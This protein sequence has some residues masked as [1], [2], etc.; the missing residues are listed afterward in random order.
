[1]GKKWLGLCFC[2]FLLGAYAQPAVSTEKVD[3]KNK[4]TVLEGTTVSI[5]YTVTLEDK[6][7][8]D[9]NVGGKPL[10]YVQGSGHVIPGV[11]KAMLG[12]KVGERKSITVPPEEAYGHVIKRAIVAVKKEKV[13]KKSWEVGAVV[14]GRGLQGEIIRGRVIE[15]KGDTATIDFNHPLAGKTLYFDVKVLDIK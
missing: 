11:E 2:G 13:P 3:D 12:M 4:L 15:L 8:V 5:E 10:T 14:Q 1:M 7:V 9:S 6:K